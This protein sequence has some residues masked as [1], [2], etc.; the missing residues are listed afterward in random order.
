MTAAPVPAPDGVLGY[1]LNPLTCGV[2]KFNVMCARR[3]GVPMLSVF[4]THAHALRAPVVSLKLAEFS[5]DDAAA[6][7]TLLQTVGWARS[8]RLF[9]HDW[10]DTP[11][12]RQ[13]LD[14]AAAVFC[15]NAEL[16]AR[17]RTTR[18]DVLESWC[19]WTLLDPQ[20]F[21]HAE[22]SVFSFGMAHKIRSD[23]HLK[24]RRLLDRTGL[25]F[26]VYL[27]TALHEGTAFDDS[28]SIAFEEL[29]TIYGDD[30]YFL[31][32][33]SDTA[34]YNYLL[35]TTFFAAFFDQGVRSNNTTVNAAMHCG[36][37]VITN[38][39]EFS[40]SACVHLDNVLDIQRCVELP[41]DEHQLAALSARARATAAEVMGWN[42]LIE[43]LTSLGSPVR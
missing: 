42:G 28:F 18:P 41:T 37:V 21:K 20:R 22:L 12:E 31:G 33:L 2:A 11:V 25:R 40:P 43:H 7:A 32:Y 36:S 24:V 16:V 30:I 8:F 34:V 26:S 5:P 6:L 1:H 29:R 10:G 19:P 9:L 3:L 35:D 38:L 13:L 39:D 23:L 27:S 15:G 14:S 17:L 4:D